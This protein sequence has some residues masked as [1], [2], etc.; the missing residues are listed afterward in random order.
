[1]AWVEEV[2]ALTKPER[3]HWCDGSYAEWNVLSRQLV[4]AGTLKRLDPVKR[5]KFFLGRPL[6]PRQ[7]R[8][9]EIGRSRPTWQTT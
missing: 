3:V 8:Q 6:L 5:P 1:L 7:R 2:A 4:E 9:V